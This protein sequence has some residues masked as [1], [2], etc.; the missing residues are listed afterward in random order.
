MY[1]HC[2]NQHHQ[3]DDHPVD[4]VFNKFKV[5]DFWHTL[6]RLIRPLLLYDA[7]RGSDNREA[8]G[9]HE[10]NRDPVGRGPGND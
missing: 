1:R 2:G 4:R 10:H 8:D 9:D 6:S 5:D 7:G 3:N